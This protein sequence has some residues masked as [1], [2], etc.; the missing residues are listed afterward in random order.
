MS[1]SEEGRRRLKASES[2]R[3]HRSDVSRIR[4]ELREMAT[5]A[6]KEKKAAVYSRLKNAEES[7]RKAL[8]A[9]KAAGG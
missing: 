9:K 7:L 8:E 2:V 4:R 5:F 1:E 3:R 6:T